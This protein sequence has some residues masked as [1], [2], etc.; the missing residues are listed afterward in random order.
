MP[1]GIEAA[2]ALV[3]GE[4]GDPRVLEMDMSY[5][6]LRGLRGIFLGLLAAA[7]GSVEFRKLFACSH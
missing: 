5:S 6:A 2:A 3:F 1:A 7:H 4:V